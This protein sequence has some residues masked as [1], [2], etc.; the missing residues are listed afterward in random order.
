M[1][2]PLHLLCLTLGVLWGGKRFTCRVLISLGLPPDG[3]FSGSELSDVL[4]VG[5]GLS[6]APTR[7]VAS[8]KVLAPVQLCCVNL[9]FLLPEALSCP[10]L[11]GRS[12]HQLP[13]GRK[14]ALKWCARL[15]A[16]VSGNGATAGG[17]VL[18]A[19]VRLIPLQL[20]LPSLR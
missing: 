20:R 8:G 5:P 14:V 19:L 12:M 13:Y 18:V 16:C 17:L 9:A 10:P 3:H 2:P 11:L 1:L 7:G 4:Q 6:P 15:R